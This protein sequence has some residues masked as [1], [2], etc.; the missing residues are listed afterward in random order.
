M[1]KAVAF[2]HPA[3]EVKD[4]NEGGSEVA[5]SAGEDGLEIESETMRRRQDG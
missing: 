3:A 5:N 4:V 1:T 2:N